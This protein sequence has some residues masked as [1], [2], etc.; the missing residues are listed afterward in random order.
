MTSPVNARFEI[1]PDR[2]IHVDTTESI[3]RHRD[4]LVSSTELGMDTEFVRE[5]TFFPQP[6]LLQ[7]S[8]G[9]TIWLLDPV[10]LEG[11]PGLAGLLADLMQNES[12]VKILHS[13]GEDLEVIDLVC[14]QL[15]EPLFDTQIAAAMLGW[16]LQLR[17]ETLAAELVGASFP[18]GLGRNNWR[19][20]P[21]P[22]EWLEYAANDVIALPE[23]HAQ[24]TERLEEKG[25]LE[26]HREDCRRLV[27]QAR[28]DVDPIT[29]IRGA[30]RLDDA[31]LTRLA[32]LARW[33]DA[34]ARERDL[35]RA[36]VVPDPA[37]LELARRNPSELAALE[38]IDSFR[39]GQAR[40][41]GKQIL[42]LLAQPDTDFVRP[43]ELH[44]LE[45]EQRDR[46]RALQD[47]V[48]EAAAQLGVEPALIASKRELTRIVQGVR[49]DWLDG[50]RGEFLQPGEV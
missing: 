47:R 19:R 31:A 29:R 9:E 41:F 22:D 46:V 18:G 24:F 27:A 21:L 26:W 43:D 42:E 5:R 45:V 23:M 44:P 48:G 3:E 35:P 1:K 11:D 40:R 34:Q 13:V 6:G 16:P 49:P 17:Y 4:A 8:D 33:R 2:L 12:Q 30:E 25:R 7:F 36:F 50:W 20:R 39:P 10:Q 38:R 37:L 32:T 28:A 14:G 15:P